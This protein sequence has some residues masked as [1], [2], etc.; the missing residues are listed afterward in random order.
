MFTR[1]ISERKIKLQQQEAV[2]KR[3]YEKLI[4]N[5]NKIIDAQKKLAIKVP[6]HRRNNTHQ[7]S[8]DLRINASPSRISPKRDRVAQ[9]NCTRKSLDM[10]SIYDGKDDSQG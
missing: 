5:M 4:G 9:Y 7:E 2:R 10:N 6:N 1:D 8:I 3:K